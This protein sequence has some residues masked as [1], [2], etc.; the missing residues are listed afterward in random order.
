MN[1][2]LKL[3]NQI[4]QRVNTDYWYQGGTRD[5]LQKPTPEN[6]QIQVSDF[7]QYGIGSLD[8]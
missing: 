4:I 7:Q 5:M 1:K 2:Q 3:D 8:I 6:N